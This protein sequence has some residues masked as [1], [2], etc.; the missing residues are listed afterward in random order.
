MKANSWVYISLGNTAAKARMFF[1]LHNDLTKGQGHLWHSSNNEGCLHPTPNMTWPWRA[2]PTIIHSRSYC[3]SSSVLWIWL[4]SHFSCDLIDKTWPRGR[5]WSLK[6]MLWGMTFYSLYGVPAHF[7]VF[8]EAKEAIIASRK[9]FDS[10][11]SL[12]LYS[13]SN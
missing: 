1:R 10:E 13:C 9:G 7:P 8:S 6:W 12:H 2:M 4:L 3:K 5:L 11:V